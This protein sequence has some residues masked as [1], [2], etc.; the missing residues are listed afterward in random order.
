MPDVQANYAEALR[1][2]SV[3]VGAS[4]GVP[5]PVQSSVRVDNIN[6]NVEH[7]DS[8]EIAANV[9]SALTDEARNISTTLGGNR[10]R[11]FF[12]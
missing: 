9:G 11:G 8:A 10:H 1:G 3:P 2:F 12:R 7:G 6:V 5:A 4:F